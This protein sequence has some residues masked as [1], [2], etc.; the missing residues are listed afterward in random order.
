MQINI[1]N[2][3]NRN[4]YEMLFRKRGTFEYSSYCPQIN[5]MVKGT[6]HNQVKDKMEELITCHIDSVAEQVIIDKELETE[7][8]NSDSE[9]IINEINN[10]ESITDGTNTEL[11]ID[12]DAIN[13]V[14]LSDDFKDF[15]EEDYNG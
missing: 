14:A 13:N 7:N 6:E 8:A 9:N 5:T 1:I 10:D 11:G 2:S 4:D 3:K 12:N 15:S